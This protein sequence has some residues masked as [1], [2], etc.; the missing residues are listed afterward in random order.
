MLLQP[1]VLSG[2]VETFK[3]VVSSIKYVDYQICII[4]QSKLENIFIFKMVKQKRP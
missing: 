2:S 4:L 3:A 1:I